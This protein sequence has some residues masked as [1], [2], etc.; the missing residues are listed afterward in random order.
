M[1]CGRE[2]SLSLGHYGTA[3]ISEVA[4]RTDGSDNWKEIVAYFLRV[5]MP[6]DN[7][8]HESEAQQPAR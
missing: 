8:K 6:E 1:T 3:V 7:E 2:F 5:L 4:A